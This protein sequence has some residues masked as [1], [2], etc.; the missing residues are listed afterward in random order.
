MY[1]KQDHNRT[2][3]SQKDSFNVSNE[4]HLEGDVGEGG[5]GGVLQRSIKHRVIFE[6]LMDSEKNVVGKSAY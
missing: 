3:P 6:N 4:G 1:I 2:I 5:G